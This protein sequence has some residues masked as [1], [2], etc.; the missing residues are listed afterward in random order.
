VQANSLCPA[1]RRTGLKLVAVQRH[2]L[3][4]APQ[5]EDLPTFTLQWR[6]LGQFQERIRMEVRTAVHVSF[7]CAVSDCMIAVDAVG[8]LATGMKMP[9][10]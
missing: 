8:E 2:I 3:V 10:H 4:Q 9:S 1:L 5:W 7:F 6:T